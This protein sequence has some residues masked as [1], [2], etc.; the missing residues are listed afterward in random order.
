MALTL[1][2]A[3]PN[4]NEPFVVETDASGTGMGA[5]LSQCPIAFFSLA[6]PQMQTSQSVYERE[7]GLPLAEGRLRACDWQPVMAKIEARLGGWKPRLLSHGGRF[8]LLQSILDAIP[9]YFMAIFK[10]LEG[11]R[12]STILD[13]LWRRDDSAL[14]IGSQS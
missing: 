7:R 5:V 14:A 6:L 4:F 8:I 11:V 10:I 9:I 13:F 1:V 12:Q 2:L 3:L